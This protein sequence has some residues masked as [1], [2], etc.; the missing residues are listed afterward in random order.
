MAQRRHN[1]SVERLKSGKW[2]ARFT[3]KITGER[4]SAPDT[5]TN[6]TDAQVWLNNQLA[7]I[8]RRTWQDHRTVTPILNDYARQ[9]IE[10]KPKP[11]T[12]EGDLQSWNTHIA[13]FIGSVRV[14]DLTVSQVNAWHS[15]RQLK[16][17]GKRA[18][19]KAYAVLRNVMACAVREELRPTNPC[20]IVGAGS[21]RTPERPHLSRDQV[22]LL[23]DTIEPRYR[24]LVLT[25]AYC[26]LRKG[27]ATALRRGDF[28]TDLRTQQWSVSVTRKVQDKPG[29]G[30]RYGSPKTRAGVRKVPVPKF[31]VPI[32]IEHLNTYVEPGQDSL[33]FTSSEGSP[34]YDSGSRA[35]AKTL[36]VLG[37]EH[38]NEVKVSTHDLRH[39]GATWL[40]QRGTSIPDL[41][42]MLGDA[43]PQ[44][45]MRYTHASSN[46]SH[47]ADRLHDVHQS[48]TA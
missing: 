37:L 10:S 25:L 8:E 46:L 29:G 2:R 38:I 21:A 14:A 35:I 22:Q 28:H 16:G 20:R 19:S 17:T 41:Q 40:V 30:W 4:I 7:D 23:A 32:L 18:L 6:K 5:F 45:A 12:V 13:P 27:E 15:E 48:A 43:S 36:K 9:V 44:A 31:L 47:L 34:A 39:T 3:H 42:R 11:K 26:L 24:A 33:V 1:G